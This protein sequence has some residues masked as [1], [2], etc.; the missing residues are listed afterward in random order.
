MTKIEDIKIGDIVT[1]ITS[2]GDTVSRAGNRITQSDV[3]FARVVKIG[4][5][6]VQIQGQF[7]QI[8]WIY[9]DKLNVERH[10]Y[11]IEDGT[12]LIDN[13]S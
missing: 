2:T 13:I 7:N 10:K 12:K 8:M 1:I 5:I 11:M 3:W 6:K 9:P 4:K